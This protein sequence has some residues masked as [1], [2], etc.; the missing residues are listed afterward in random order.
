MTHDD[1][2]EGI[3]PLAMSIMGSV[4]SGNGLPLSISWSQ[5]DK[6]SDYEAIAI[7]RAIKKQGRQL[8]N[9]HHEGRFV[10]E[11]DDQ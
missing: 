10:I 4:A 5:V 3:S 9:D 1:D 8:W 7:D 11:D 6:L 2:D